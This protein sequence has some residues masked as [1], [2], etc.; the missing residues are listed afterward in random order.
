MKGATRRRGEPD[1]PRKFQ[2][3]LP[4]K[5]ATGMDWDEAIYSGISI[6][7]PNEGSDVTIIVQLA[8]GLISI[9]APNE[10]SDRNCLKMIPQR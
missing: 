6:H 3:T 1:E 5:G 2:S 10:G 7:A 4:M 8:S 9:H